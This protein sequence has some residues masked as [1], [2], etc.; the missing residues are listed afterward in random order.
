MEDGNF[1]NSTENFEFDLKW[2]A[3]SMYS[4]SIDTVRVLLFLLSLL[5]LAENLLCF[6]DNHYSLS[7]PPRND[8]SSRGV[9]ESSTGDRRCRRTRE[10][11]YVRG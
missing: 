5:R 11:T 2:T 9:E 7:L 4:A 1:V 8:G 3:N 6:L 10:V